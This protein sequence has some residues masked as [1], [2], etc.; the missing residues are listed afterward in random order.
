M[1]CMRGVKAAH[2]RMS[3]I[4]MAEKVSVFVQGLSTQIEVAVP[5]RKLDLYF[6]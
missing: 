6:N 2:C 5:C 3:C 4:G 1:Q